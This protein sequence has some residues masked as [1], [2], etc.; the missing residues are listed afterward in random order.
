MPV[1]ST[2]LAALQLPMARTAHRVDG[3]VAARL[4]QTSSGLP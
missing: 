4:T 3:Y 2:R 1:D